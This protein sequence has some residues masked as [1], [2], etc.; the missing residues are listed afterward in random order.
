MGGLGYVLCERIVLP[1]Q[2]CFVEVG[3]DNGEGST[4]FLLRAAEMQER[5]FWS[6]D[7]NPARAL[8]PVWSLTGD[9]ARVIPTIA[10][11][12]AFAYLDSHDWPYSWIDTNGA[13]GKEYAARGQELTCEA[14]QAAHLAQAQAVHAKS[15]VGSVVVFDDTWRRVLGWAGKGGTAIPW[16]LQH[17]W[18]LLEHAPVEDEPDGSYI[19]LLRKE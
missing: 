18:E 7:I 1:E 17:G 4:L 2:G 16:L 8:S 5:P 9:G 14:S 13:Q 3:T 15:L 6:I 19:A 11:P 12:I 10:G